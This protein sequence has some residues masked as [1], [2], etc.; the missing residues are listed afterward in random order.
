MQ[1]LISFK[2]E[3]S[4]D[5]PRGCLLSKLTH[6]HL[7]RVQ[8]L[9]IARESVTFDFSHRYRLTIPIELHALVIFV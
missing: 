1:E 5:V 2:Q 7:E 8:G 6:P 4:N 9:V 3:I